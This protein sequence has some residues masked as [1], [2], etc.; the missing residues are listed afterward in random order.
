MHHLFLLPSS[1]TVNQQEE[2]L[3]DTEYGTF[4]W[5]DPPGIR[6]F[7]LGCAI[8]DFFNDAHFLIFL[9]KYFLGHVRFLIF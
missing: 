9:W 6:D 2:V 4:S 1:S 8:I 5:A 7:F 3:N